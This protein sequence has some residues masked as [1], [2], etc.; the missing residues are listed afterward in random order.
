LLIHFSSIFC[1]SND[2]EPLQLSL[3]D[4]EDKELQVRWF[5]AT[6]TSKHI[7]N[8]EFWQEII[9]YFHL[10]W[11]HRK[12]CLYESLLPQERVYRAIAQKW[13]GDTQTLL[14]YDTGPVEND[15]SSNWSIVACIHCHGNMS[16]ELLCSNRRGYTYVGVLISLWLFLF[17]A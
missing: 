13:L 14:W 5:F 16:T 11:V 8:K 7:L 6:G 1:S 17:A 2:G 15:A 3:D 9:A 10:I 4:D 12:R